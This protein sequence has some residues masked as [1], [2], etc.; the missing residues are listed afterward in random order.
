MNNDTE[1][2]HLL[3]YKNLSTFP[4][5]VHFTTTRQGGVSSGNYNSFNLSVY[6]GDDLQDVAKN[7]QFL[8][9]SIGIH[10]DNLIIP[11]QIH[12]DTIRILPSDFS[13]YS[14][15]ERNEFVCNTDALITDLPGFCIGITV[16]DCVPVLLYDAKKNIIAAVHAGW[17]GTVHHIVQKTVRQMQEH[18]LSNPENIYAA[19]GPCIGAAIYEVGNEVFEEFETSGFPMDEISFFNSKTAKYHLNLK[20]AN[21]YSLLQSGLLQENIEIA[22]SCTFTNSDNFFSARKL[23]IQSGRFISGIMISQYN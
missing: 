12:S 22:D 3:K 15:S 19:I 2:I 6:S 10:S 5:I 13:V 20:K 9:D 14:S 16:A 17:R 7:R 21:E 1:N 18:F 11:H 23:G 8:C 4:G